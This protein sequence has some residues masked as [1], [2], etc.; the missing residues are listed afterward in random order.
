[1]P[2]V[3]LSRT[4]LALAGL[5]ATCLASPAHAA[6]VYRCPDGSYADKPC[7]EGARVVTTT[8]RSSPGS[9]ADRA[10]MDV[11]ARAEKIAR[12]RDDGLP[13]GKAIAAVDNEY[14]PYEEKSAR[15]K[16]VVAVYRQQGTPAEVR[17]V[18]EA[19]CL[20]QA[21]EDAAARQARADQEAR[22]AA[23]AR[24]A[25]AAKAKAD[26]APAAPAPV[27]DARTTMSKKQCE[28]L[29]QMVAAMSRSPAPGEE[30]GED[31]AT[32]GPGN[33]RNALARQIKD[34]C[35]K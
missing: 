29:R 28:E 17:S 26:P 15:R 27:A 21:R 24:E 16:L 20:R 11:G 35:P 14:V 22:D 25:A 31:P 3:R 9:E 6:K 19:E 5:V 23:A 13:P 4:L 18:M 8:R 2:S 30:P 1:M 12:R 34:L 32:S 10:C 33:E 7:G